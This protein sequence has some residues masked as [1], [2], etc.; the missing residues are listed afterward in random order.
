MHHKRDE[1]SMILML[2]KKN[3]S[4][5]ENELKEDFYKFAS[6]FGYGLGDHTRK[7][8]KKRGNQD[9]FSHLDTHINK[10]LNEKLIVK[11]GKK[12]TLTEKGTL[13]AQR[14]IERFDNASEFVNKNIFSAEA[15]SRN[16]V[17][18]DALLA[19]L[20][21]FAGIISGSVGLI[22]DGTDAALDTITAGVVFW[23]VKR[24]KEIIGTIVIIVMM[25]I[26]AV[27]LGIDSS[28]RVIEGFSGKAQPIST[29]VLVIIIESIA[30]LFAILLM[31]YQRFI[32]KREKSFALITQSVDSKNHI[33]VAIAVI[34]GA[35]LSMM[36]I[37]IFDSLIG[38]YIAVKIFIDAVELLRETL[39]SMKGEEIDFNKYD[40]V[41][42]RKWKENKINSFRAV[43][44][45]H[46]LQKESCSRQELTEI[47]QKNFQ[48]S[49]LPV[50]SEFKIGFHASLNFEE[51]FDEIIQPL[52][53]KNLIISNND[54][55]HLAKGN[56]VKIEEY[57]S[58]T[59]IEEFDNDAFENQLQRLPYNDFDTIDGIKNIKR[60]MKKEEKISAI[61]RAKYKNGINTLIL[62]NKRIMILHR[63]A[64]D[65]T[66]IYLEDIQYI[67]EK[68]GKFGTL[69]LSIVTPK[70]NFSFSYLSPRKSFG[71]ISELH[72]RINRDPKKA[73][74][75]TDDNFFLKINTL[76][77]IQKF[78]MTRL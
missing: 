15:A 70:T 29:P 6:Q 59:L 23:S 18:M 45:Y 10:L 61:T 47:L 53:E 76:S 3:G 34:S 32:G 46:L 50:L 54:N 66:T 49:Y 41:L 60:Y 72:K 52:I 43:I 39:S 16:T 51:D 28:G 2:L 57:V 4:L 13:E 33:Y 22:A 11:D 1:G 30:L 40:G 17:F 31:L 62:S 58:N 65:C 44:I 14:N 12:L 56:A 5:S 74:G 21:L 19:I 48:P 37:V 69:K 20:K 42:D 8:H 71:F 73:E 25:F 27:G 63:K 75:S 55:Y 67:E 24:K 7:S 9:F 38:V 68:D 35:V 36:G 77:R 26:T 78:I 64:N